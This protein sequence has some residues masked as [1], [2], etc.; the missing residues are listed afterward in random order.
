MSTLLHD[1]LTNKA[2]INWGPIGEAVYT[3]TY[4]RRKA[5]GTKEIWPETVTRVVDGNLS[6]VDKKF[7]KRGERKA[8]ID[9]FMNFKALPAG[10]HLWVS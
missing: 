10:R 7:I 1:K 8:L 4:S 5:D 2:N 6:L 3:R 9:L